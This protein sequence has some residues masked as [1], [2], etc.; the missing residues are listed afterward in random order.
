[1]SNSAVP[2]IRCLIAMIL[3][4]AGGSTIAQTPPRLFDASP[5]IYKVVAEDGKYR[6]I[7][8]NYKPGQRSNFFSSPGWLFYYVTDCHIRKHYPDGRVLDGG[9]SFAGFAFQAVGVDS[10]ALENVG[11]NAC[12]IVM[13]EPK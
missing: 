13:F 3:L 10:A 6:I 12:R 11:S 7:E 8:A 9:L 1:M 5:D 4:G 2:A